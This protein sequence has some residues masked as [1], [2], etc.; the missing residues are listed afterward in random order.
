MRG[1]TVLIYGWRAG[2]QIRGN[3]TISIGKIKRNSQ[4]F[5]D[6]GQLKSYFFALKQNSAEEMTL[7]QFCDFY[8]S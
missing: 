6:F 1:K 3:V 8:F 7:F 2:K 5:M 4:I